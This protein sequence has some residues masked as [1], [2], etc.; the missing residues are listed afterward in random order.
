M[1]LDILPEVAGLW[2]SHRENWEHCTRCAIGDLAFKHVFARGMLPCDILFL[3]EAP[4]DTEDATGFPF[5]GRA[6][7]VFDAMIGQVRGIPRGW[8][9]AVTNVVLCKPQDAPGGSFREPTDQEKLNCRPR[10]DY[11]IE[12][13]ARP[14]GIVCLGEHASRAAAFG[15][16]TTLSIRH[17]SYIQR[18][19]GIKSRTGGAIF[20]GE[21]TRLINF[22]R[23]V[24]PQNT[25]PPERK[26]PA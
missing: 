3:G 9:W 10:L 5:V 4:G 8:T 22:M 13:I 20:D 16:I 21:V 1:R 17:P 12:S 14:K 15:E 6:G 26:R 23:E 25:P 24:F 11:F 18:M 7:K 19:G 2:A